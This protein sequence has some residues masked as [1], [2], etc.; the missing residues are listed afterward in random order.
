MSL[1]ENLRFSFKRI[2]TE[3]GTIWM[4]Q[5]RKAPSQQ[6]SIS[7]AYPK[8]SSTDYALITRI[9]DREGKRVV[10][11]VGGLSQFG[12]EAA[13]EFLTDEAALNAFARSAPSGWENRNL[14]IVLGMKI[15]GRRIVDPKILATNV[16]QIT[17]VRGRV[18]ATSTFVSITARC[19]SF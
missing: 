17:Y 5:D 1:N 2:Q 3:A 12:T 4:I 14:Q 13:G 19:F 15:D 11:S 10:I 16:W 18:R 6:W 7:E 9:I 8:Q